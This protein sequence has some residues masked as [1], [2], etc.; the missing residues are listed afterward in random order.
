MKRYLLWSLVI[1]FSLIIGYQIIGL[2]RGMAVSKRAYT[3]EGLLEAGRIDSSNPVPFHKLAILHQWNLLQVDL[4]ASVR[5]FSKAIDRNPLEQEYWLG[6][7]RTFQRMGDSHAFEKALRNAILVF[8]TSY[9][10]RW[11]AGN[12]LLQQGAL[13]K[14]LPHFSYILSHYP[15]RSRLVYEVWRKAVDPDFILERLIPKDP[16]SLHQHLAYL[17]EIGDKE[18]A[19]K[20]WARLASLNYTPDRPQTVRH[21]EFLIASGDF[22]EAAPIWEAMLR[23]EGLFDASSKNPITNGGF[24]RELILGGGFDWRIRSVSGV[25]TSFDDSVAFEGNRSLKIDF[26]GNE[27]VNFHHVYQIVALKPDTDYVLTAY[28]KTKA[29]TTKSGLRIEALGLGPSFHEMSDVLIGDNGWTQ[30]TVPFHTPVDSQG[31]IIRVRRQKTN[32]FDRF[33]S[34]TVWIDNVQIRE[35]GE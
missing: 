14:S 9:R 19:K 21:I 35:A 4:D 20:G 24:E 16:A 8:P 28:M 33:I 30:L 17:Y 34:G 7:A 6:L 23:A 22:S 25:E 1:F 10:G 15:N 13:E 26:D 11:V 18:T 31:G 32:K 12:L 29:V 27:N 2:W 3:R 5:N